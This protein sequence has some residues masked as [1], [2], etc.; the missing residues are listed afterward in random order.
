MS[1]SLK[2]C[3]FRARCC[4]CH[5]HAHVDVIAWH[6]CI[7]TAASASACV[8]SSLSMTWPELPWLLRRWNVQCHVG[9]H[10]FPKHCSCYTICFPTS[11]CLA[12]DL[13]FI[14][15]LKWMILPMLVVNT[16]ALFLLLLLFPKAH[17]WEIDN[18]SAVSIAASSAWRFVCAILV[19]CIID[20]GCCCVRFD[21]GVCGRSIAGC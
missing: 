6:L 11:C 18:R 17:S 8:P 2:V 5:H 19:D 15:Y 9:R 3:E 1:L 16:T 21:I 20:C 12:Y 14:G 4:S 7:F 13:T 10:W